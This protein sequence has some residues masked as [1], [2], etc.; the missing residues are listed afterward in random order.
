M[1][2]SQISRKPEVASRTMLSTRSDGR[3]GSRK[4][5]KAVLR[6]AIAAQ[7]KVVIRLEG[8]QNEEVDLPQLLFLIQQEIAE[9]KNDAAEKAR[10]VEMLQAKRSAEV[11][12]DGSV[13][14]GSSASLSLTMSPQQWALGL[15]ASLPEDVRIKF[16]DWYSNFDFEAKAPWT[17]TRRF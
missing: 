3:R 15:A 5:T 17:P 7:E 10:E 11:D 14:H 8:L 13:S 6:T 12:C 9:A 1:R 2:A 4:S 16:E